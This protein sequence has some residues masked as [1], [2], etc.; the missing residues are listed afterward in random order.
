MGVEI[1]GLMHLGAMA[2][3][4]T[5]AYL[6]YDRV[7]RDSNEFYASLGKLSVTVK[8][9]FFEL[10]VMVDERLDVGNPIVDL[11]SARLLGH[12]AG[13]PTNEPKKTRAWHWIKCVFWHAP[14]LWF[15]RHRVDRWVVG[16]LCIVSLFLFLFLVWAAIEKYPNI[17]NAA[18]QIDLFWIFAGT[19]LSV[20]F[21]LICSHRV[22]AIEE[23][24]DEFNT[25]VDVRKENARKFLNNHA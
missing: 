24:Y 17:A 6:G 1:E 8:A 25:Q 18:F 4:T 21:S 14:G 19:I 7:R 9:R 11:A 13:I 16:P 20:F 22:Q 5:A 10:D 3:L 2:V 15:F 12:L 23:Q